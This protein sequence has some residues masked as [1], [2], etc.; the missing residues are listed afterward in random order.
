MTPSREEAWSLVCQYTPSDNLRRH[1]VA[2]EAV[3][4]TYARRFGADEDTWGVIGLV[5]D[6]D[7][8]TFPDDHPQAG[9]R[10]LAQRGWPEE[11]RRAVL[12][13]ADHTGVPRQ[14]LL[15]RALHASDDVT[16]LVVAAALVHP[17]KDVRQVKLSSLRKKWKDRA[18][19]GGVDRNAAAA[20]AEA[21]DMPLEDHLAVVLAAMQGVA[22]ELGLAGT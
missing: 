1:M 9:E 18:F 3:M 5:H 22:S 6:F 17:S 16:G 2:V 12:S 21:I 8:E 14:S 4:R 13:H 10:I 20:A 19:A 7:Y 11:W 15:E